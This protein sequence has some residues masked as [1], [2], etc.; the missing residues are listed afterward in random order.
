MPKGIHRLQ[1]WPVDVFQVIAPPPPLSSK[2][3]MMSVETV[4]ENMCEL[5]PVIWNGRLCHMECVRPGSGG[6]KED[7][8]LLVKDAETGDILAKFAEGY[9]LA[10]AFV[11]EGIFYA[12][13]SRFENDTWN[14]VTM[15]KSRDLANWESKVVITQE[16][17]NLFNSSVCEGPD[18][19]VMAYESNEPAYPAFTTK[20]AR[21]KDLETWTKLPDSTF[22]TN[23]YTACPCVRFVNGFYY[24]LYLENRRPR[25]YF[26]TY[27]T[28]SKDLEHWELSAANPVL[29][30]QTLDESINTSDPDII[31]LDGKTYLY[32]SAGDQLT[33]MN[34]KRGMYPCSMQKFFEGWF[35]TPGIPDWG[36]ILNHMARVEKEQAAAAQKAEEDEARAARVQWFRDAKFGIYTHWGP[37]SVPACGPNGTWYPYFMYCEGS[38]QHDY[39]VKTYGPVEDFGYKDFI[40]MFTGERFDSDEWADLFRRAGARFAG[41]V[42]EHHDGFAMWDSRWTE[43]N[44]ARMGPRRDVVGE[45][46]KAIRHQGLRYMVALHH[47]ENWWFFPHWRHEFD[48]SDPR[49]AGLYGETHNREWPPS[50]FVPPT[51]LDLW[52]LQDRP[53]Q[54][55]LDMWLGKAQE[56][57]DRYQPD[58]LYLDYALKYIQEHYK[59]QLLAYYYNRA[60]EWG[61]EVVVTYKWH[62]EWHDLVPGSAVVDLELGRSSELSYNDWLTDTTVDDG[63]GWAYLKETKYKPVSVLV[64]HLVDNV[65]KNGHLLLNVGP[66]PNG[67]IPDEARQILL[68]IGGW[69]DVNGEAIYGTTPW[70]TYGEGP[71][72]MA[73]SGPFCEDQ[74][75]TYTAKDVRFTVKG[76]VLYAIC[77]GWPGDAVV[78]RT[79]PQRLY[80]SEIASVRMLGVADEL[81][82]TLTPSGLV[83]KTPARRPCEHAFVFRIARKHPFVS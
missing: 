73:R 15:F 17:E 10:S 29:A 31:E 14:D 56:V 24:V 63:R 52:A 33:W 27:V 21:S 53:S 50:M 83:I 30:P 3:M 43:W 55:F 78:L 66:K 32:Y 64:H 37:Y 79:V 71:T 48:T 61:K 65:S 25:H 57:I 1:Q 77:L 22:G 41:P 36:S 68:A 60:E 76:D 39:H 4:V 62:D 35:A 5:S 7:Y 28:R 51:R 8:Y 9:S 46:A 59:R 54:A 38:P 70:V 26:E 11:H 82:W 42:G 72:Q 47:A 19:F 2:P 44:A 34:I 74:E 16:N 80:P 40:P 13:A 12:F 45:L 18:G 69:L 58:L 49:Y 67:E 20:F 75:I 6:V 81:P 23:R